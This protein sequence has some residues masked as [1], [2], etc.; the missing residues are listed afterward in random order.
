MDELLDKLTFTKGA[1]SLPYRLLKPDG[2]AED[3]SRALDIA[4][5]HP[6]GFEKV[7]LAVA[8]AAGG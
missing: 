1:S 5:T 7:I 8:S 2:Y 6:F 4:R 3:E